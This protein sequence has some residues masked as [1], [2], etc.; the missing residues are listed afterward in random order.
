MG[1]V[2]DR[3]ITGGCSIR[4]LIWIESG[5]YGVCLVVVEVSSSQRLV[6]VEVEM[7]RC[8]CVYLYM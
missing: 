5:V 2:D 3:D 7:Y 4:W 6:G 1:E 8:G